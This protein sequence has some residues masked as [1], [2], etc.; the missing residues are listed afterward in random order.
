MPELNPAL[1]QWVRGY[2]NKVLTWIDSGIEILIAAPYLVLTIQ[3]QTGQ[4][5]IIVSVGC[6]SFSVLIPDLTYKRWI[7]VW[8]VGH[9]SSTAFE[10]MN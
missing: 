3:I 5:M 7:G 4:D 9:S 1:R 6:L 10:T 2:H 8:K